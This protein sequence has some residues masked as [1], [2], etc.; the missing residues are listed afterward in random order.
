MRRRLC[1]ILLPAVALLVTQACGGATPTAGPPVPWTGARPITAREDAPRYVATDGT[2]V[3][4]TT[5]RTQVGENALRVATLDGGT[6]SR[7]V[8][9]TPGGRT[10]NGNVALDGD[11]VYV[12]ADF[13]IVRM[14]IA[15]GEATVVVDGRPGSIDDVVAAGGD[16]W[17]TTWVFD[18]PKRC[19]VARMP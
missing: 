12:A 10:P 6:T 5:G 4:F 7:L 9:T 19:E 17:W 3:F 18:T 8:A 11:V 13:G 1:A 14:P 2:R 15:G 16:L